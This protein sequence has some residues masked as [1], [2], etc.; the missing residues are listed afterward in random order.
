MPTSTGS[1][2]KPQSGVP[3]KAA[4]AREATKMPAPNVEPK[5]ILVPVDFSEASE[6]ALAY[7]VSI[8]KHFGSKLTLLYVSQAQFYA[9]EFGHTPGS[10]ETIGE[11]CRG[12]LKAFAAKRVESGLIEQ[13]LVRSG[14]PFD[15]IAKAAEEL[16]SELIVINTH[17]KT[18]LKHAL[19]GSTAERVVRHAPCPVLVV[20]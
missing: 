18:G 13:L 14:V 16:H 9:S 3:P 20:R 4:R 6:N 15:E 10:E 7:A 17:G 12:I 19:L 1:K 2:D 8:A 11:G 5:T